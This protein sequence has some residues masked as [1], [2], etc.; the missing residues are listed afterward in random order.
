MRASDS[1]AQAMLGGSAPHSVLMCAAHTHRQTV[2]APG[3]RGFDAVLA[4]SGCHDQRHV[5]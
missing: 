2:K 3:C 4:P 1:P 5:W